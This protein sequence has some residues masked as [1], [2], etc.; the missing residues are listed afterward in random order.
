MF[1]RDC[2]GKTCNAEPKE[3]Y[4]WA[5]A[6]YHL[7]GRMAQ[8]HHHNPNDSEWISTYA[9]DANGLLQEIETRNRTSSVSK[10]IY[11]YDRSGRLQRVVARLADGT[12]NT[13]QT[14]SY[15]DQRKT[16][17]RHLDSTSGP[18]DS[19]VMYTVEGSDAAFAA[20]GATSMTTVY[21]AQDRPV[22]T[23][24]HDSKGRVLSRVT[25][26]YDD[27]GRMVEETQTTETEATLPPDMLAQLNPAQLQSVKII[28]GVGEGGQR[29][30]R[31]HRYDAEGHRVE[32]VFRLGALG[33]SWKTMAYNEHGDL[34]EER[35]ADD[36]KGLSVDDQGHMVE[37]SEP[38]TGKAPIS[39]AR[40]SYQYDEHGNWIERV[41]SSRHEPDK[42][43][44][45][46][47]VD[48]RSLAYY[49]AG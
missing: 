3:Q 44:V 19:A 30:K 1:V 35:S 8:Y 41:I 46:S 12:E 37:A 13:A 32:T 47:S 2:G 4:H 39:E 15:D 28:L 22:E 23:L 48:R 43:F 16:K 9:Y 5:I 27:G 34:S 45:V 11:L 18:A 36:S 42:P 40:F 38:S 31:T 26:R 25:L 49:P 24:F 21:D 6:H 7:D 33:G 10:S 14:F 20:P 17:T 29:W